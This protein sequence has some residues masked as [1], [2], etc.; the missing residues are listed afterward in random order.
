MVGDKLLPW[1]VTS[2]EE[3]RI[4]LRGKAIAIPLQRVKRYNTCILIIARELHWRSVDNGIKIS[5]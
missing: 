3:L 1:I 2:S 5:I 4:Y